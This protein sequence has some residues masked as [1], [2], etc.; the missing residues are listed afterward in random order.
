MK[1]ENY[2]HEINKA[3][4]ANNGR[5][6]ADLLS[7]YDTHVKALFEANPNNTVRTFPE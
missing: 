4:R 1:L 7:C 6:L 3:I 5:R 2:A